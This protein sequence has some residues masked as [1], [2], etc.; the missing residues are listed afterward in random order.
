[1]DHAPVVDSAKGQKEPIRHGG[2][3]KK[4]FAIQAEHAPVA[5]CAGAGGLQRLSELR[6]IETAP[7]RLFALRTL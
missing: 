5:S 7:P 2:A 6:R 1:M 3:K 4:N